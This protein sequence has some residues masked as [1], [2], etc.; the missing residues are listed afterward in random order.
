MKTQILKQKAKYPYG[1]KFNG[2]RMNR[3]KIMLPV[4]NQNE[5]DYGYMENY[6]KQLEYKKLNEYLKKKVN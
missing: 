1:Y 5:P 6:M 2:T 3:Q 4:N